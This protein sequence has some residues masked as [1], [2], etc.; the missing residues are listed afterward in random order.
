MKRRTFLLAMG[1][2]GVAFAGYR[3]RVIVAHCASLGANPDIDKLIV[4]PA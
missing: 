4:T 2:G 3:V 1:L